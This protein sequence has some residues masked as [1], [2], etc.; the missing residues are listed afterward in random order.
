[1]DQVPEL[2]TA[3]AAWA[4]ATATASDQAV[5]AAWAVGSAATDSAVTVLA[6]LE[7]AQAAPSS[8]PS[9]SSRFRE[10]G[11]ALGRLRVQET[12]VWPM[13]RSRLTLQRTSRSPQLLRDEAHHLTWPLLSRP[14]QCSDCT[15]HCR[16]FSESDRHHP[17]PTD[18]R[19]SL[20]TLT[21]PRCHFDHLPF[22]VGSYLLHHNT[23]LARR[24]GWLGCFILR[25]LW[26]GDQGVS[27]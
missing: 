5:Q 22:L 3:G 14:R 7:T 4:A 23:T 13:Q 9:L 12:R 1:M 16:P 26:T 20:T 27:E 6:V 11:L 8:R 10:E 25:I 19:F 21:S 15:L 2:T 24:M 17:L 18:N